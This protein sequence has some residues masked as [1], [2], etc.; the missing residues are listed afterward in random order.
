M[1]RGL[2]Y[3]SL[4]GLVSRIVLGISDKDVAGLSKIISTPIALFFGVLFI[5]INNEVENTSVIIFI[6]TWLSIV[7]AIYA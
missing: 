5:H 7:V 2:L 4:F 1:L 6:L 3:T